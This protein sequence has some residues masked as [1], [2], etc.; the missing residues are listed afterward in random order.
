MPSTANKST[1][2]TS[3]AA[4]QESTAQEVI[5]VV[6]PKQKRSLPFLQYALRWCSINMTF[7]QN[8]YRYRI[9]ADLATSFPNCSTLEL[10]G[11]FDKV[12]AAFDSAR[13][14]VCFIHVLSEHLVH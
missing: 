14:K 6:Q 12:G 7:S 10:Q 5:E 3:P 4:V 1:E 2:K 9:L 8:M 13:A 11:F